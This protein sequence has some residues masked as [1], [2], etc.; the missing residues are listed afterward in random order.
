MKHPIVQILDYN[1]TRSVRIEVPRAVSQV[2]I[3]LCDT[4]FADPVVIKNGN[5]E[6]KATWA[7]YLKYR[8]QFN[9]VWNAI[10]EYRVSRLYARSAG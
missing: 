9:K 3:M 10:K 4:Y 2:D 6:Y 7:E 8:E 5:M 1:G